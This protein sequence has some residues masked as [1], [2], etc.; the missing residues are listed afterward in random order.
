MWQRILIALL[1]LLSGCGDS[2]T[3]PTKNVNLAEEF[4]L[5]PGQSARIASADLTV[6]FDGVP[7]DSRCPVDVVCVWEGDATVAVSVRQPSMDKTVLELHTSNGSA[8]EK[9][10]GGYV[11]RLVGLRPQPRQGVPIPTADY[12]A[13]FEVVVERPKT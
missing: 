5:A 4:E 11:V 6:A 2:P 8:R 10:Y 1:P 3:T 9:P 12:R 13:R 7:A